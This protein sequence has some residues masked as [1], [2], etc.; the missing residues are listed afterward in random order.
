MM[1][2]FSYVVE[3]DNGHAPNPY[4]GICTLC[5]CKFREKPEGKRAMKGRR[6]IVELAAPGDW[7]LGTGGNGKRSAG[8]GK[9]VYAMKVDE[10][11]DRWG[12]F[13]DGRFEEKKRAKNGTYDKTR[14]D[15]LYPIDEFQKHEQ[16]ALVSWHFY[17]FGRNAI[18]IP[19]RFSHFEKK[20]PAFRKIPPEEFGPFHE[21][22]KTRSE[23]RETWR[24]M[25][26]GEG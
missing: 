9:L 22:L 10:K 17:Y 7:I 4:F 14:G 2:V 3:H 1:D 8:H 12:Y 24:T 15:N 21:W 6:N 25:L 23:A 18:K 19:R 11:L 13:T 16:F 20:G 5:R 26:P